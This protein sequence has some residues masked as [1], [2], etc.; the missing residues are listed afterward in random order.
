MSE[1]IVLHGKGDLHGKETWH[2]K[3]DLLVY[4]F[5]NEYE[6]YTMD[7]P[8]VDSDDIFHKLSNS[9]IHWANSKAPVVNR[10][11]TRA[12][13]E[14]IRAIF[15][16]QSITHTYSISVDEEIANVLWSNPDRLTKS[17]TV[18]VSYNIYPMHAFSTTTSPGDYYLVEAL[19][20]LHGNDGR[21]TIHR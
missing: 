2:E 17:S 4:A 16:S 3:E 6:F 10:S 20:K 11:E 18:D 13:T 14:D 15:N 21:F 19:M 1:G 7:V 5:N 12:N 8:S 9:F